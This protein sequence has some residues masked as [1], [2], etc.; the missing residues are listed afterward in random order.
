M[1]DGLVP[2]RPGGPAVS[3]ATTNGTSAPYAEAVRLA[4]RRGHGEPDWI[5]VGETAVLLAPEPLHV[6]ADSNRDLLAAAS[7]RDGAVALLTTPKSKVGQVFVSPNLRPAFGVPETLTVTHDRELPPLLTELG[8][9]RPVA[10]RLALEH[11]ARPF[12]TPSAHAGRTTAPL[13]LPDGTASPFD[14]PPSRR[15]V[16]RRPRTPDPRHARPDPGPVPQRRP[17]AKPGGAGVIR[18]P[19]PGPIGQPIRAGRGIKTPCRPMRR[20]VRSLPGR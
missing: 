18:R 17:G 19:Q 16:R 5:I 2:A 6:L 9:Y 15:P 12:S 8:G 14:P 10:L 20:R 11:E 3:T 13:K 4:I 1:R 7:E